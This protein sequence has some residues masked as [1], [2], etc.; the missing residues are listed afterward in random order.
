M[1]H[2]EC[3]ATDKLS[4]VADAC[5]PEIDLETVGLEVINVHFKIECLGI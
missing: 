1:K 2:I 5:Q 3:I 4:D